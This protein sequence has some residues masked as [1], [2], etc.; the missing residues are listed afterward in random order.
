MDG[1][2]PDSSASAA[3]NTSANPLVVGLSGARQNAAIAVCVR[4]QLRAVCELERLTRVRRAG[5]NGGIPDPV[6]TAVLRTAGD[7]RRASVHRYATGEEAVRLPPDR[8][9]VRLEHHHAHAATA[10]GLSPFE[11]AAVLVCDG[12]AR[13]GMTVW[14]A[15]TEA[16]ARVDWPQS[17]VGL[18]ALYSECCGLFGLPEGSEHELEALSR[19]H[20]GSAADR[21][22]P[23]LR[24]RDG[25]VEVSPEWKTLV[26]AWLRDAGADVIRRAE[27]ASA[28]QEHLGRLLLAVAADVRRVTGH[29]HLCLGGG[30]FYNTYFNT[31]I[32]QSGVFDDVFV[33]PNPGNAGTALGAALVAGDSDSRPKHEP[34]SPFLGPRYEFEEI[35]QTLDNC[36]LSYECLT[37]R[38]VIDVA[39]DALLRGQLVGWFQG[40]MEWGH[41]ALGNRSILASPLSPW[42]LDNLNRFLKH[43]QPYRTYGVSIPEE[44]LPRFFA[45]PPASRFM[46]FEYEPTCRDRLHA[47]PPGVEKLRVQTIPT[48]AH[49]DDV[50]RFRQLHRRFGDATGLPVL[51]NTSFNG[52]SEPIV[53]SPRDAIRVFF[54][55]G[56]DLLVLDRFVLRK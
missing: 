21:F 55:T 7:W 39:V 8:P 19:L 50:Q 44:D 56:L 10:C 32:R 9:H 15:R 1:R 29:P 33:A 45:G 16:L 30:L 46:E 5:M 36:K 4:G 20:R 37:E 13:E 28:F 43:R 24:Y 34:I 18:A 2:E 22:A 6:L 3:E 25:V 42:V 23:L 17:A 14:S 54:G 31:V 52:F 27:A 53:C 38:E 49:D 48:D 47:M 41:R 40:R 51:I 35:K 11:S 12:H 26:H